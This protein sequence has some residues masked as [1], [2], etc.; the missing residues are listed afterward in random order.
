MNKLF[1]AFRNIFST[2]DLRNRVLFTLGLLAVYRLGGHHSDARNQY[3]AAAA[4]V[5]ERARFG[6]GAD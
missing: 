3:G 4:H 2:P 1:E 6:T 5:S